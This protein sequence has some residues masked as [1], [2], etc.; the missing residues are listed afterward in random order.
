MDFLSGRLREM[1]ELEAFMTRARSHGAALLVTGDPG[2][3]KTE[4]LTAAARRW[5]TAGGRVIRSSGVQFEAEVSYAGLH[6]VLSPL[7][8]GLTRLEPQAAAALA[9]AL[10]LS[11]GTSP[12]QLSVCAA[13]LTLVRREGENQ[14][15][16][17]VADD[18]P[19]FDRSSAIVLAFVARRVA[20]SHVG[21]LAAAR[22]TEESFFDRVGLPML[23][24]GPLTDEAASELLY[25]LYPAL[26]PQTRQR[27]L[28][29]AAGN[30]LALLELPAALTSSQRAGNLPSVLPLSQRLQDLFA[31]RILDLPESTRSVLLLAALDGSGDLAVLEAAAR[32]AEPAVDLNDLAPAERT[33][34]VSVDSSRGKLTFRHPLTRSAVV[35]LSTSDE[36]R[37]A[38]RS[39][40][41]H[42]YHQ[43][44][45]QAWHLA[46]ASVGP[47]EGVAALLEAV[48]H[49]SIA[50]GD[51][52]GAVEA[53]TRAAELSPIG[54][55][56]G[57]RFAEAAY[58]GA[59]VTG[60]LENAARLLA[61]AHNADPQFGETLQAAATAAFVL[62]NGDGDVDTAHR[63]LVGAIENSR[64]ASD[65]A[66]EHA[67]NTLTMVCFFGARADLWQPFYVALERL[68]PNVPKSLRLISQTFADPARTTPE[69]VKNLDRAVADLAFETDPT[70]IMQV[71]FA[72]NVI[73]RLG[74]ARPALL[75]VAQIGRDSG[76]AGLVIQ[77]QVLL[78]FDSYWTGRWDDAVQRAD[79]VVQL[80]ERRGF[81]LF[82]VSA[83]HVRAAVAAA[84]GD[85][86]ALESTIRALISWGIPKGAG[87][88]AQMEAHARS[89]DA[90]GR[91]GLRG[92]IPMVQQ[93]QPTWGARL[94]RPVRPVGSHGLGG[95]LCPHR[96]PM[97]RPRR[98]LRCC[99]SRVLQIC[100][101][102]WPC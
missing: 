31:N 11:G 8:S 2:I 9:S 22:P 101:R 4:L 91:A 32:E 102:V 30:P 64:E 96:T 79:E 29:D 12:D 49:R 45:M 100:R 50:R 6:Q 1:Q 69:G 80:C 87:L 51:G 68:E 85:A 77:A 58:A 89:I 88:A 39:L 21:L 41:R 98:M 83:R 97:L 72:A 26:A 90:L 20:G 44:D 81:P 40:A 78:A 23:S 93:H 65:M 15:L 60:Q 53:L 82:A 59:D 47:D 42:T 46:E 99:D 43:L 70:V 67:L 38:H 63:L 36:R 17:V 7:L 35:E 16:L 71:G 84:R 95:E 75:R 86:N 92:G 25:A 13:T 55:E 62:V 37:S 52:V 94:T 33:H 61:D 3:G 48:A 74:P 24:V 28:A 19:W 10:G 5:T 18:V 27:L 73:D 14:P 57:R 76:A 56:R 54:P 66:L 34:V